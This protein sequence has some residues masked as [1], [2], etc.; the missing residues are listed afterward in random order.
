MGVIE[1]CFAFG[2]ADLSPTFR[3][4]HDHKECGYPVTFIVTVISFGM[5]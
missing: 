1:A 5:S 2:D 3:G 4:S